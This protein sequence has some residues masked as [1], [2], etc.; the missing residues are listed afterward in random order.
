MIIFNKYVRAYSKVVK[1]NLKNILISIS[2]SYSPAANGC[3]YLY[4]DKSVSRANKTQI[5]SYSNS[6]YS[7]C[8]FIK[9]NKDNILFKTNSSNILYGKDLMRYYNEIVKEIIE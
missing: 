4:K 1:K 7:S 5:R 6:I 8:S 9:L 2:K 3:R